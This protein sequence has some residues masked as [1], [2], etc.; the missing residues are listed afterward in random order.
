MSVL[1]I[2]QVAGLVLGAGFT[3]DDAAKMVAIA[4]AESRFETGNYGDVGIQTSKWG[5]S[6]GLT[7]IRSL[8]A[9]KGT[10]KQRDELANLDPVTNLRH[11]R[12]IFLDSGFR[13]WSTW[14]DG[15]YLVKLS[16][17][18]AAVAR[19]GS[20]VPAGGGSNPPPAGTPGAGGDPTAGFSF[21]TDPGLW[22]RVGLFVMGG[23]FLVFGLWKLSGSPAAFK[24]ASIASRVPAALG[25]VKK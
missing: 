6:V 20:P 23:A 13:P 10:G 21:F 19:G 18:R 17:A 16:E 22:A 2:D 12:E 8:K 14:L 25:K 7:Q 5:P 9:D 4:W 3:G 15:K 1:T 11:A 24:P